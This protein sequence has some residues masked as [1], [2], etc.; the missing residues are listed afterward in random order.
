M[1]YH[2]CYFLSKIVCI[3]HNFVVVHLS[4]AVG[5]LRLC[6]KIVAIAEKWGLDEKKN[7]MDLD[8]LIN[9]NFGRL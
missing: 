2:I 3:F 8:T 5:Y 4:S 1:H 7:Y 6:K 9:K